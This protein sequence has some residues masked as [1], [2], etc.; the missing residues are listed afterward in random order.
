MDTNYRILILEDDKYLLKLLG[1][2]LE[3]EGFQ[4]DTCSKSEQAITLAR[5]NSYD[6]MVADIR[7]EGLDGLAAL[8]HVQSY[9]PDVGSL[10]V[11]GYADD[12]QSERARRL[13]LGGLLKKPFELDDFL[14]KVHDI[15][16]DRTEQLNAHESF[17]T[18]LTSYGWSTQ[19]IARML[20]VC[21]G[22][23]LYDFQ[24]LIERAGFLATEFGFLGADL[25][26]IRSAALFAAWK[27]WGK[28]CPVAPP[29]DAPPYFQNWLG[30]L[31]E[32]WN[33]TGPQGLAGDKIPLQTRI[34][35]AVLA[36]SRASTDERSVVER[37]PGRFD[38]TVMESMDG[39]EVA[40]DDQDDAPIEKT[41]TSDSDALLSLGKTLLR[42]GDLPH[43]REALQEVVSRGA[44]TREGIEAMLS[45]AQLHQRSGFRE[46]AKNVARRVPELAEGFGPALSGRALKEA[47]RLLL[48]LG[49]G[50]QAGAYLGS[51]GER[52]RSLGLA[53]HA[54]ECH[55]LSRSIQNKGFGDSADVEALEVLSQP[56]HRQNLLGVLDR[57]LTLL[58]SG[59]LHRPEL[60]RPL[61]R[62]LVAFPSSS[63][64]A[65]ERASEKEQAAALELI[66]G[67]AA[68]THQ[69]ML[70]AFLESSFPSVRVQAQKLMSVSS[71]EAS[72]PLVTVTSLG[73]LQVFVGDHPFPDRV[74][75]TSKVRF[76]FARLAESYPK[77]VDEDILLEEFWPKNPE[78][79][80]S[81]LYNAT[82]T[83]RLAFKKAGVKVEEYVV[84]G[85]SGLGLSR[86]LGLEH[87]LAHFRA[88]FQEG[89]EHHK[90][91]QSDEALRSWRRVVDIGEEPYL[92]GC[93]MNWALIVREE[94]EAKTL[95]ACTSIFIQALSFQRYPEVVEYA[96]RAI[97]IDPCH[98]T[99]YTHLLEAL[100]ALGRPEE[101]IRQYETLK[102]ALYRDLDLEPSIEIE[103]LRV[104]AQLN[105]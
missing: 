73:P 10:V 24:N 96:Q 47:G 67:S 41:G 66:G 60:G 83:I 99:A 87:D 58:L 11:S 78:K 63:T 38:P 42:A 44:A 95:E 97:R 88:A 61:T 14:R 46:E 71:T 100:L 5:Q 34:I 65:L 53:A 85:P 43:A 3:E 21:G 6:L 69:A 25:E 76:L 20:T 15:L 94:V 8:S 79:G 64:K 104:R 62:L 93:Y 22:Q 17:E 40:V 105:I 28:L 37:W 92:P 13:G 49:E 70:T 12:A 74:W 48:E 29:V 86:D 54:A 1:E 91:G 50:E 102:D 90:R 27:D 9:Q 57:L 45:L 36:A 39:R 89:R 19:Q 75:K 31:G 4:V 26:K 59:I 35:V 72:T 55:I 81:S 18:L 68:V 23:P 33:G 52:F 77:T 16:R 101:V 103:E 82:S 56:S 7:M 98:Q 30:S 32:W 84:R 51:A 80:R 2:V